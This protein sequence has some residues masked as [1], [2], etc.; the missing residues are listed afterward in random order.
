MA[1][2]LAELHCWENH[3]EE[4]IQEVLGPP[5]LSQAM[6]VGMRPQRTV[7]GAGEQSYNKPRAGFLTGPGTQ[8]QHAVSLNL[9]TAF[10]FICLCA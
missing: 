3:S 9:S 2:C 6:L 8:E 5:C 10:A 4:N 7:S 1:C